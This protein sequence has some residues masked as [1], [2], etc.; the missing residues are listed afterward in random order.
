MRSFR[1][2]TNELLEMV[3]KGQVAHPYSA[4]QSLPTLSFHV[5]K[6]LNT[7][8]IPTTQCKTQLATPRATAALY[9]NVANQETLL[10]S[11]GFKTLR[12]L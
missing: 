11:S 7:V 5:L 1:D 6:F 2:L 10:T 12:G 4:A 8:S 9:K 3:K